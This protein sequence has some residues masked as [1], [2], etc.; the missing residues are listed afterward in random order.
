MHVLKLSGSVVVSAL[1]FT[2]AFFTLIELNII[3]QR[4]AKSS[5]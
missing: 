2:T 3:E 4:K 1:S 5:A